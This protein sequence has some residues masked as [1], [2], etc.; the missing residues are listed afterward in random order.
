MNGVERLLH[1][2]DVIE[3]E[4]AHEIPEHKPAPEWPSQGQVSLK[5]VVMSYRAGLPPVLKGL[6]MDI[7]GGEKI[8]IVGRTGAGKSSIMSC[9]FR[10]V[11]LD[12]GSIEVDGI[13][14]KTLGLR[15]LRSRLASKS[16]SLRSEIII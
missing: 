7:K 8:G 16:I 10:L 13:D 14:I 11:E 12:S 4:P 5:N 1:Y 2:A 6:S 9:L 3:Q 15:D